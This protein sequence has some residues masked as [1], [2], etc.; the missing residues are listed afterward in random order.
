MYKTLLNEFDNRQRELMME[1]IELK[2]VL[3]QMKREMMAVLN[4][5]SICR[6]EEKQ[7]NPV[8]QVRLL[9]VMVHRKTLQ[10]AS[11]WY[12][13]S[14]SVCRMVC[15][16]FFSR[17]VERRSMIYLTLSS[18]QIQMMRRTHLKNFPGCRVIM[19]VRNSPI[20]FVSSGGN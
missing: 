6:R 12:S 15:N 9:Y 1:N 3:Q 8:D 7:S 11:S 10:V 14:F 4:S 19:P 18:K 16:V 2:K 13:T 20:A 5:M 17:P